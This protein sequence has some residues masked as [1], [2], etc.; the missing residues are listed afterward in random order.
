MAADGTTFVGQDTGDATYLEDSPQPKPA[1][2]KQAD[3]SFQDSNAQ[4]LPKPITPRRQLVPIVEEEMPSKTLFNPK[5]T[6]YEG[7]LQMVIQRSCVW[8][9][10]RLEIRYCT[11]RDKLFK[12]YLDAER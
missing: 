12:V 11:L 9:G 10:Q 4:T 5:R 7:I 2:K 3:H 1:K 6:S 8:G